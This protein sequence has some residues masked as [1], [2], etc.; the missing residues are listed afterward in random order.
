MCSVCKANNF[1]NTDVK[2]PP[3]GANYAYFCVE[4]KNV[5]QKDERQKLGQEQ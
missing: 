4:S 3:E 2:N 1:L 5:I